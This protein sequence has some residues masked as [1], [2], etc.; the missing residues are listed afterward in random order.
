MA[1]ILVPLSAFLK[2]VQVDGKTWRETTQ[3]IKNGRVSAGFIPLGRLPPR[4]LGNAAGVAG[5]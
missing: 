5:S 3:T 2:P 4:K 1:Q